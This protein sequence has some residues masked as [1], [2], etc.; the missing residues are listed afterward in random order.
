M[1]V[2]RVIDDECKVSFCYIEVFAYYIYSLLY[3]CQSLLEQQIK[4]VLTIYIPEQVKGY[5]S[6]IKVDTKVQGRTG[7]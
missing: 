4:L 7:H 2:I 1:F 6:L 5:G 3:L